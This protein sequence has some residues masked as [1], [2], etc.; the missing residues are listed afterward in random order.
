MES[1]KP[2]AD[3]NL[4][5][6]TKRSFSVVTT[7]KEP[8]TIDHE[9]KIDP[10]RLAEII[11]GTKTHEIRV[12]DR[13]FQVGNTLKLNAYDRSTNTWAGQFAIVKV[14]N[15]TAPGSYG[16]PENVG[17]MS[18]ALMDALDFR[19]GVS[20]ADVLANN[21]QVYIDLSGAQVASFADGIAWANAK[22]RGHEANPHSDDNEVPTDPKD[23]D[24]VCISHKYDI[25][26]QA[27][28]VERI[29][30]A[31]A[32]AKRAAAY[33]WWK[34]NEFFGDRKTLSNL[35]VAALLVQFYGYRHT[36]RRSVCT[37][38][39]LYKDTEGKGCVTADDS[40]F[41]DG[42]REAMAPHLI[43]Q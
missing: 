34:C 39:D 31:S 40:L 14:T 35:G 38:V 20:M 32:D 2:T 6:A 5:V 27:V 24:T 18:I 19:T 13:D 41:R 30:S 9:L 8:F 23:F 4:P 28:Y 25:G 22:L 3:V 17:A 37:Q 33:V 16:L 29:D 26:D 10:E 42:L 11:A 15:I 12:F 7:P 43:D 21:K 36:A 1:T